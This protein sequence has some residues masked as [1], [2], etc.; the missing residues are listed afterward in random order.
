MHAIRTLSCAHEQ[1]FDLLNASV[2]D[3]L[4][5]KI[6]CLTYIFTIIIIIHIFFT[7][8]NLVFLILFMHIIVI[9]ENIYYSSMAEF[10]IIL[11]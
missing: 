7:I 11:I 8:I 10:T 3:L 1:S 4:V 5:L 6:C 2:F 9:T